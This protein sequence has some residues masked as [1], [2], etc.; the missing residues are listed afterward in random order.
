MAMALFCGVRKVK[1]TKM[2][3]AGIDIYLILHIEH[4]YFRFDVVHYYAASV[5]MN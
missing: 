3:P 2:R 1:P 5:V 4:F